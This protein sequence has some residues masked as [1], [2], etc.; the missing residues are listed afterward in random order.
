[1]EGFDPGWVDAGERRTAYYTNLPPGRYVFYV[2]ARSKDGPW[3]GHAASFAFRLKPRYYQT[4]WFYVVCATT[5][6]L[7]GLS[8]YGLRVRGMKTRQRLL[9]RLVDARTSALRAE[10][11]R[12]RTAQTQLEAEI[13]ERQ[14]IQEQ[15]AGATTRAEAA[16]QA[17]GMFL[18]N[19]SHE[20]RTPMNGIL[21]M[22][23]LLLDTSLTSE[24]REHLEMVRS[25]AESLL[26]VINDVLDFSKIDAG[27]LELEAIP[28]NLR[29]LV[30][31]TVKPFAVQAT[32]KA[33]LLTCAIDARVPTTVIG[34]P[35]RLRQVLVNLLGN[36]VKF[37][38]VGGVSLDVAE[39][40]R[41]DRAVA[42]QVS[43]RDT[44]IGIPPDKIKAVFEPFTQADGSTTR[45][46]GGTGLGLSITG[47][48]VKLMG[49]EI[50]AESEAGHG[51]RFEFTVKFAL[52]ES[53]TTRPGDQ[54]DGPSVSYASDS[55]GASLRVLTAEDNVVNQRLIAR[56]LQKWGHEVTIVGTG[57]EAVRA[58]EHDAFD[59][60][61]MDVQ[62]PGMDG[63]EATRTIRA[64]EAAVG[65][66]L[67]I[68]A[69]TAHAMKGDR[70]RCLEAGMDGY[71]SKPI[72][73]AELRQHVQYL[74]RTAGAPAGVLAPLPIPSCCSRLPATSGST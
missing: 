40:C 54:G 25:S 41:E 27:R 22:T 73:A 69:I 35:G 16:N 74:P 51:S 9:A 38:E 20:I 61:L 53:A 47:N 10:V 44:G 39:V 14:Q 55:G 24:Q 11:E 56:L 29:E 18:A 19:M 5:L 6:L 2:T 32:N 8:A 21:G 66:R 36:S 65:R 48:L 31:E 33:L 3:S 42:I 49:G 26:S 12:R 50:T 64:R 67:T 70:E 7:M 71:L 13:A 17:K 62:M 63:F 59:L 15:L 52:P 72:N 37:T 28:F 34:D 46:Y 58:V 57:D 4:A 23:E 68:L 30:D 1:M 43:V 60:V 45:R